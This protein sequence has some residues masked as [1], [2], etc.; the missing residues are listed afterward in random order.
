MKESLE[1]SRRKGIPVVNHKRWIHT[2][3]FSQDVSLIGYK[4]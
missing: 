3:N 1:E 4:P 2:F